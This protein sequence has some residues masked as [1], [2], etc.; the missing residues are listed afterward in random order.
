MPLRPRTM[1]PAPIRAASF[2][3]SHNVARTVQD[4]KSLH[5]APVV[6]YKVKDM[7]LFLWTSITLERQST[8]LCSK[9]LRNVSLMIFTEPTIKSTALFTQNFCCS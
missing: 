9:S 5:K 6:F 8:D 7:G 3:H 2:N 4:R 1:V